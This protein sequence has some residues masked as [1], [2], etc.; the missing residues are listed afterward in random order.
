MFRK[1][2]LSVLLCVTLFTVSVPQAFA[3]GAEDQNLKKERIVTEE[4]KNDTLEILENSR[5]SN[6]VQPQ[7][8]IRPANI[9]RIIMQAAKLLYGT[10]KTYAKV[11]EAYVEKAI[12]NEFEAELP[13][14]VT[15][16]S[17][18]KE[19]WLIGTSD[20]IE[21]KFGTQDGGMEHIMSKHHPKYWTGLGYKAVQQNSFFYET[22]SMRDIVTIIATVANYS[23]SNKKAIRANT[24]GPVAVDG[25]YDGKKYR[26]VVNSDYEVVTL[27]PYGW[28]IAES[29]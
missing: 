29:E 1:K 10:S 8:E 16:Y 11:T 6:N 24:S 15:R 12:E 4:I 3:S 27:Y 21:L 9:F 25:Y 20:Y 18:I 19:I 5:E 23:E 26:L 2:I 13:F 17:L 22:T 28:N 7:N 14:L